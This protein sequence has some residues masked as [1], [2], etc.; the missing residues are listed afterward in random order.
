MSL[1]LSHLWMPGLL[2]LGLFASTHLGCTRTE[3]IFC[4]L[5]ADCPKGMWC[6]AGR[7]VE[8]NPPN[9]CDPGQTDCFGQCVD[10][11]RDPDNCGTCGKSCPSGQSC[12]TGTCVASC[13]TGQTSCSRVCV[14]L[15][16]DT[17]NCG[18]CGT[19]CTAS[20]SCTGSKCVCPGA[21]LACGNAC[22]D[23]KTDP[24]NCGSCGNAC[25]GGQACTGGSC[26]GRG[27]S[28]G[29]LP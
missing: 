14:D 22:V 16:K 26:G 13:P 1:S 7:C 10:T 27:R 15:S 11:N 4:A 3:P 2:A 24:K 6:Q 18:A 8:G 17:A 20:Q 5:T 23:P 9:G 12:A 25:A 19:A 21:M 28:G 29:A